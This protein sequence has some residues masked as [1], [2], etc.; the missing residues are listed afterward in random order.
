[1]LLTSEEDFLKE[2]N[3]IKETESEIL[4]KRLN[5]P[6]RMENTTYDSFRKPEG[7][8]NIPNEVKTIIGVLGE[9]DSQKDVAEVFQVSK[10]TVGNLTNNNHANSEVSERKYNTISKIKENVEKK[11]ESCVQFIEILKE[12]PNK[13]L[14][15][16]AESLSRIHRNISPA[17]QPHENGGVQF[18]FYAPERQN[19][20][21]DYEVIDAPR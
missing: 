17:T 4:L 21:K 12:T 9:L 6:I 18:I 11:I 10:D 19:S 5:S 20:I 8:P 1:M 16:T 7:V 14:L 15:A 2:L 3:S 13:E